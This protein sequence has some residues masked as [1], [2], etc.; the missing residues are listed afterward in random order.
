MCSCFHTSICKNLEI[1]KHFFEIEFENKL[2][3]LISIV[4]LLGIKIQK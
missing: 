1:E 3:V 4:L 2:R